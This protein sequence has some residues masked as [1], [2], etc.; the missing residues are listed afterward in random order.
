MPTLSPILRKVIILTI[1][2]CLAVACIN[3]AVSCAVM[4]AVAYDVAMDVWKSA[5]VANPEV[6]VF[7]F[8]GEFF[9]SPLSDGGHDEMTDH[10]SLAIGGTHGEQCLQLGGSWRDI[11]KI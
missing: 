3:E 10:E 9:K 7:D 2:I 6:V 1:D 5:L 8:G 11:V 4:F